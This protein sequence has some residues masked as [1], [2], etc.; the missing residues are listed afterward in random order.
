MTDLTLSQHFC[1]FFIVKNRCGSL[2][3]YSANFATL[4]WPVVYRLCGVAWKAPNK[5]DR[6]GIMDHSKRL[7]IFNEISQ[8]QLQQIVEF[9]RLMSHKYR[10][11]N[12]K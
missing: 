1:L 7:F 12:R 3:R 8:F 11:T 4:R 2:A 9:R 5:S 6:G 10:E